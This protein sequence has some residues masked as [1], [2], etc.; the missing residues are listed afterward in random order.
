MG[1]LEAALF[2]AVVLTL[3]AAGFISVAMWRGDF[4]REGAKPYAAARKAP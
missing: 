4:S 2:L 3:A 1:W